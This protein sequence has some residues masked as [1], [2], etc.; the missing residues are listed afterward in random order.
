MWLQQR[1][2]CV[3]GESA[4]IL[5]RDGYATR[6]NN[7][8]R[9]G[10]PVLKYSKTGNEAIRWNRKTITTT[11]TTTGRRRKERRRREMEKKNLTVALQED[12]QLMHNT[13]FSERAPACDPAGHACGEDVGGRGQA[14]GL[15]GVAEFQRL[16][17]LQQSDVVVKGH[18]VVIRV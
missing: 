12:R 2:G 4:F 9:V 14:D 8:S 16:A 10:H 7:C 15:D 18:G 5:M 3:G 6:E 1:W 13:S 17:Q 11:T